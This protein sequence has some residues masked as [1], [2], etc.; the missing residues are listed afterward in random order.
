MQAP[1]NLYFAKSV[2]LLWRTDWRRTEIGRRVELSKSKTNIF[3]TKIKSSPLNEFSPEFPHTSKIISVGWETLLST[4]TPSIA[5][6]IAS[7]HTQT[8]HQKKEQNKQKISTNQEKIMRCQS[9]R[10]VFCAKS[11]KYFTRLV[12]EVCDVKWCAV[13]CVRIARS[14]ARQRL[15][16]WKWMKNVIWLSFKRVFDK[17][18]REHNQRNADKNWIV[19]MDK[20]LMKIYSSK[21]WCGFR[22]LAAARYTRQT[23]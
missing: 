16:L 13:L 23:T 2:M 12:V 17:N 11:G 5:L 8:S 7:Q 4:H 6:D 1:R 20:C 10:I 9:Q 21:W 15:R 19:T 22:K 3:R 14:F 18:R